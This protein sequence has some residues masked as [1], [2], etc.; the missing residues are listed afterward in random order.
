M[1]A[2]DG[3]K[4][5]EV[6]RGRGVSRRLIT[7]LKRSPL[8]ITRDN[9]LIRSI[10]IVYENDEIVLSEQEYS[11]RTEASSVRVPVLYEDEHCI[12][13][14]K[15]PFMPCHQSMKHYEDTLANVFAAH[16][17]DKTFRCINRL[18]KN[19]SGCVL[20]AKSRLA[21]FSL[22][23]SCRK[24]YVGI[25]PR[26]DSAGGRIC[27]P[28]ARE[29]D[30]A[31]KRCVREGGAYSATTFYKIADSKR[32]SLAAFIPE[33]GRTHQIRVHCAHI[34]R[35][36][37]GDDMYGGDTSLME[38]QALHCLEISF[39][40]PMSDS[41]LTVRSQLPEDMAAVMVDE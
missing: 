39:N 14:D 12:V 27:A 16:C 37:L 23:K 30:S 13:F 18:D 35:P 32:A 2:E 22:Q 29:K 25:M 31:I 9:A 33:T 11:T 6:L 8:G 26:A 21:A 4:L 36:L 34:G 1:A 15:P 19:T 17:P 10:D 5:G 20:V 28:I 41:R 3:K 38:R 40:L 7:R 24:L